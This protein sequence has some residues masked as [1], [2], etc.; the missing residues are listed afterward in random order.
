MK[1]PLKKQQQLK[2]VNSNF[3]YA[4]RLHGKKVKI[5]LRN[6][7]VLD[8]EVNGISNYEIV[9]KVGDRNLLVFKHAIDYIEY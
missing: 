9:V 3:E 5:F 2:K 4:R 7:E 6:G 1:K 8:A